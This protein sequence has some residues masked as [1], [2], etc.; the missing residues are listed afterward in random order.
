MNQTRFYTSNTSNI[1]CTHRTFF[2]ARVHLQHDVQLR[3]G[4]TKFRPAF[5]QHGCQFLAVDRFDEMQVRQ[6]QHLVDLVGLQVA[7][8]VPPDILAFLEDVFVGG[9]FHQFLGI[10]FAEMSL[11]RLVALY[12][13]VDRLRLAHG[14]QLG[15]QNLQFLLERFIK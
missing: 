10:V 4:R 8:E 3:V 7:Y 5:V 14:D 2:A 11:S 9:L 1:Y 13:H 15:L 6:R 12:D